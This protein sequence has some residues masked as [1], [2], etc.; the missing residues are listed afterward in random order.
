MKGW[1]EKRWLEADRELVTAKLFG[2][3]AGMYGECTEA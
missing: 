3:A 2:G 1:L